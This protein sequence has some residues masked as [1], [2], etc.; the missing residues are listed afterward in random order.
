VITYVHE[1]GAAAE[2][3]VTSRFAAVKYCS[4][5]NDKTKWGN[6]AASTITVRPWGKTIL[7]Q[8]PNMVLIEIYWTATY[9]RFLLAMT[10]L[11]KVQLAVTRSDWRLSWKRWWEK[12]IND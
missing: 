11:S 1:L 3:A 9:K 8:L 6:K 12:Y 7:G 5:A 10:Q 2:L 4:S